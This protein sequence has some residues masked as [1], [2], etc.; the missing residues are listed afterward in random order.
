MPEVGPRETEAGVA[1][2]AGAIEGGVKT[3]VQATSRRLDELPGSRVRRLRRLSRNPLPY[4]YEVHPE[5]RRAIPHGLGI[6]TIAVDAIAGTAVGPPGQRGR[7]FLP[8]KPMRSPNWGE[9]WQ[10]VRAASDQLAV[11]PPIDVQ[12]YAAQYW[13]LD[14]HNRVAAALYVGQGDID[15]N[16]VELVPPGGLSTGKH[17]SVAN[18]LEERSELQVTMSRRSLGEA[19]PDAVLGDEE[20]GRPAGG[21]RGDGS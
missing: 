19:S 15:A 5:A 2:L 12:L 4:L 20:P 13:V 3:A 18:A 8:P 6:Q 7:D 16:V 10:R 14:G 9:R 17:A 11:L 1:R 21:I